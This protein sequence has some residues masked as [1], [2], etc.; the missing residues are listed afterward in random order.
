MLAWSIAQPVGEP[1]GLA[2]AVIVL[3]A[4]S[5]LPILALARRL[6]DERVARLAVLLWAFAPATLIY[7]ATSLD[8]VF[9]LLSTCAV[10]LL[11]AGR[12]WSGALVAGAVFLC[13]YASPLA[14]VWAAIVRGP[15]E[16]VRIALACGVAALALLGAAWLALGYDAVGAVRATH[17]AYERG[18][19]GE[20][21]W[22]YWW[23]AARPPT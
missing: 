8:A 13:S 17:D 7:G 15:R 16:G 1:E 18:I 19:G 2:L 12:L 3:G 23:F 4:L 5:A 21:P 9:V 11:V 22:W 14:V 20:R 6:V 10:A